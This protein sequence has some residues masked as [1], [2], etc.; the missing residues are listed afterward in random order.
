MA[1][2][3]GGRL[4]DATSPYLLQHAHNPVDW[5]P[6]GDE[7]FAHARASDRPVFLSIGYAACHWCH[8]MERESFE[9]EDTAKFL[10]DH[11]VAIKVDRE[12]RPDLDAIYMDAVQAMTGSGGWPMSVFLTP[13]GEPFYAGT[14][15][16]DRPRHGMPSF[17]QVLEGITDAWATRRGEVVVQADRVTAAIGRAIGDA[18]AATAGPADADRAFADL[19]NRFDPTRGGFGAAPKFPQPMVLEWLLRQ[20]LRGR[21]DAL[22]MVVITLDRMADGGIH[23]QIGGGF[24]RYSTDAA[25]HVPHFEKL[26]SDN[27]Q[28]LQLYTHAWLVT[29]NERFRAVASRTA[30]FL[31]RELG[32]PDGG[33]ASSLDADS[34][35]VE[36]AFYVWSW[37]EL[38]PIVGEPVA[39]AL[40]ATPEGNWEGTNVLWRPVPLGAIAERHGIGGDELREQLDEAAGT[41]LAARAERP[42]PA[43]DDKVVTAWNGLAIRALSEAGRAFDEPRL[44]GAASSCAEFVW[45]SL[46]RDDRLLRSWR[47]GRATTPAFLDDHALLGLG[48]LALYES[49]GDG[50]WFVR[51]RR[52]GDDLLTLFRG[53]EGRLYQTG[54]DAETLLV[55][56]RDIQDNALPSGSSA[57]AE[58]L[59]RLALFTGQVSYEEASRASVAEVGETASRAPTAFGHALCVADLLEGPSRE[60]AIVGDFASSD[61]RALVAEVARERFLPNVVVAIGHGD[62]VPLLAG[63][64]RIDGKATAYVCERFSCRAPVTDPSTL[65]AQLRGSTV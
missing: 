63:R 59:A 5:Y 37:E 56:P 12:E 42:R 15:F 48:L 2:G 25:W 7:A 45:S 27:A 6:W 49:T 8:V 24:A 38:V 14:Y 62:E 10:N 17:R 32:L 43:I 41:L 4:A 19:R 36:G 60:I 18:P 40:G 34:D 20:S 22:E 39:E 54:S 16:P 3:R 50:T 1:H 46:I 51:A 23:D 65:A 52:L 26:L 21:V 29:R 30:E 31:L 11:F 57:A 58:L 9:D 64:E 61:T 47:L 53:D 28:L 13:D 44:V 35:G 33:F 55:R